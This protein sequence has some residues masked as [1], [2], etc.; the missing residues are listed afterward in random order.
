MVVHSWFLFHEAANAKTISIGR[1]SLADAEAC[2]DASILQRNIF[3][4]TRDQRFHK[5]PTV[6]LPSG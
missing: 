1:D 3:A 2:R 6:A 4:V 5:L